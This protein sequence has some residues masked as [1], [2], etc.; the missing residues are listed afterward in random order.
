MNAVTN[1]VHATDGSFV[2]RMDPLFLSD[3]VL[4]DGDAAR[5]IRRLRRKQ[6]TQF[7]HTG[8]TKAAK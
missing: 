7:V 2:S 6:A 8:E 5:Q 4:P 3:V 1:D